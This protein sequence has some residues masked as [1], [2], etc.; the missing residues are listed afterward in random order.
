[1]VSARVVSAGS[2]IRSSEPWPLADL[3]ICD[4]APYDVRQLKTTLIWLGLLVLV[5]AALAVLPARLGV[6][7][8]Y[9]KRYVGAF[10]TNPLNPAFSWYEPME[11]VRGHDAGSLPIVEMQ[12]LPFRPE[13]LEEAV[14]YARAHN[15]DAL[16]VLHAGRVVLEQY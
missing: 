12:G 8:L 13:A 15:S 9:W 7:G 10:M 5:V 4:P 11:T 14:I 16:V 2:Q 3:R 1:M 6:Y